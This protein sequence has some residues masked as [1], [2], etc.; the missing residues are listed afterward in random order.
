MEGRLAH[1]RRVF[2]W[3]L[4]LL[5]PFL[6]T[7]CCQVIT[8]RG[9]DRA[10][11]WLSGHAAPWALASS[12]LLLAELAVFLLTGRF[13][14]SSLL[15]CL[16]A[17]LLSIAS[18]LKE[19]V[20]G[21]PL[22]ISDLTMAG[23]AGVVAG[24]LRPGISLGAGTLPALLLLALPLAGLCL[25]AWGV[26]LPRKPARFFCCAA[27]LLALVLLALAP[28]L[29]SFLASPGEEAETQSQRNDRL[30]LLLGL[31]GAWLDSSM[32]QPGDYTEDNMNRLLLELQSHAGEDTPS[33]IQPNVI[34]LVSES[35][36]DP[37]RLPGV[38]FE[39]DPIPVFRSLSGE[40]PSGVFLSNTYAGGTGN[41][42][43][44]L[45]TGIPSAFLG[46]GESLTTFS[47]STAYSRVPSL[48]RAFSAQGYE[49]VMV[50]TY[51]DQLYNR[52][53]NLPQMGFDLLIYQD[54]FPADAPRAGGYLSDEA[55]TDMLI[56]QLEA[57][58][59]DVP[60]FLY[61]LSMENHQPYY[62][63]KF[64]TPSGLEISS[65]V[66]D[67]DGLGSIDALAHGLHDADTALGRL[68]DYLSQWDEPALLVFLGDHLPGLYITEDKTLYTTLG[69][70]SSSNTED[71]DAEELKRMHSTDFLVWNNYGGQPDVPDVL[72]CT[73]LGAKL[74][75]WAGV[76]RPLYFQWVDRVSEQILLYRP[77]LFV[78]SDGAASGLPGEEY[79][80]LV[81]SWRSLVYDVLYG[82]GYISEQLCA[83]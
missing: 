34:L 2:R 59:K 38:T 37:T 54:Q 56:A 79:A 23:Q 50:H 51:T 30:G 45:F 8:L 21:A 36:F 35:F 57:K 47:D 6:L 11:L 18:C 70:A 13:F 83:P 55:L 26:R 3:A 22:L 31:Y 65:T 5:V 4:L 58:E 9:A 16:P 42:E 61:G 1:V 76:Q 25:S 78:T 73:D 19:Q 33:D 15:V 43:M 66:L 72:S 29:H 41:V 48:I 74:L 20:N 44:E 81:S 75:R 32:A 28:P 27:A 24:F 7:F 12:A 10:A 46:A 62:T 53:S 64:D 49:T 77:R 14:L 68:I 40:W 60:L 71:W 67:E 80:G 17:V 82:E 69:Y 39:Q 63:G 52:E